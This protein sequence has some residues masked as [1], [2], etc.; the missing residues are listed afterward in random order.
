MTI[1]FTCDRSTL[2][3]QNLQNVFNLKDAYI[4]YFTLLKIFLK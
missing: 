3:K 2:A 1:K 4:Y